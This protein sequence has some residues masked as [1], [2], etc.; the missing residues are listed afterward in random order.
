MLVGYSP[1]YM[2]DGAVPPHEHV[3]A[4]KILESLKNLSGHGLSNQTSPACTVI[5]C[6][7]NCGMY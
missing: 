1:S 5:W 3:A 6:C 2:H 4:Q 7:Y